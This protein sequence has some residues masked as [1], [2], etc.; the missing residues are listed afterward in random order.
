MPDQPK[1]TQVRT[2]REALVDRISELDE[3]A[4]RHLAYSL[5]YAPEINVTVLR[6][7]LDAAEQ[8]SA[9][10]AADFPACFGGA[11]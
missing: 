1:P 8:W 7:K 11:Q 3:T 5:A 10:L 9:K 6:S 4:V 2:A